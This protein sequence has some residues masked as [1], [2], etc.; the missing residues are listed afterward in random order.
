MSIK[1]VMVFTIWDKLIFY[2]VKVQSITFQMQC[3]F[4]K[5]IAWYILFPSELKLIYFS[6]TRMQRIVLQKYPSLINLVNMQNMRN[7][8]NEICD[9][10]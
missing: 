10:R 1:R 5:E 3:D 6:Q 4:S 2:E 8:Q 7:V 9:T